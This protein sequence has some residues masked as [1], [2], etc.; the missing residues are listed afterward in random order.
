MGD[1]MQMQGG[2]AVKEVE[3]FG[4]PMQRIRFRQASKV[5]HKDSGRQILLGW[6]PRWEGQRKPEEYF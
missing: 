4:W 3:I 5:V 2:R 1:S 6:P